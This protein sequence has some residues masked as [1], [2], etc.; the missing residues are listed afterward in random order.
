MMKNDHFY[1]EKNGLGH[2]KLCIM[3]HTHIH[4]VFQQ[5]FYIFVFNE[6]SW[7]NHKL[8]KD[9]STD[10]CITGHSFFYHQGHNRI[11]ILGLVLHFDTVTDMTL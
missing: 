10:F 11:S 4:K 5:K 7:C 8:S 1:K 9:L 6:F 2:I 3:V